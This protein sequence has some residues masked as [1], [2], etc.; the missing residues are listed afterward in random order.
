[1]KKRPY[2]QIKFTRSGKKM[3]LLGHLVGEMSV[4]TCGGGYILPVPCGAGKSTGIVSLVGLYP[5]EGFVIFVKTKAECRDMYDR[6]RIAGVA[7]DEI[8]MIYSPTK[9]EELFVERCDNPFDTANV[10]IIAAVKRAK[11]AYATMME[12]PAEL[13][14]KR[15]LIITSQHLYTN[16]L[17]ALFAYTPKKTPLDLHQ[18]IGKTKELLKS[19]DARKFIIIDEQ[20]DFIQNFISVNGRTTASHFGVLSSKSGDVAMGKYFLHPELLDMMKC[21]Y[22]NHL[23][24]PRDCFFFWRYCELNRLKSFEFLYNL[25]SNFSA[26]AQKRSYTMTTKLNDLISTRGMT[27]NLYLFDATA[28]ILSSYKSSNFRLIAG[29]K[30]RYCS[31]IK[32]SPFNLDLK[33]WYS[34]S[35]MNS[36][37]LSEKLDHITDTLENQIHS[38]GGEKLLIVTWKYMSIKGKDETIGIMKLLEERLDAKGLNGLYAIIYRG[39]GEDKATNAY[40]DYAG[41]TFLG[42]WLVKGSLAPLNKNFNIKS[43]EHKLRLS[44][45]AQTVCRV[46]I[47][48]HDG[49]PIKIFYSEDIDRKIMID[50]QQY[51]RSHS[52]KGVV[53]E[54]VPVEMSSSRDGRFISE[55][56][57]LVKYD[58]A[59]LRGIIDRKGYTLSIPLVELVKILPKGGKVKSSYRHFKAR[60]QT[61]YKIKL[62]I[63]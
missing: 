28:D 41:V 54:G 23:C 11:T 39:S 37:K 25:H 32:F 43:S 57:Q 56:R 36:A 38:L 44:G 40:K 5:A 16:F 4:T 3:T 31:P 58:P 42:E 20:P 45:M 26:I 61:E 29:D 48:K 63:L 7:D 14:T 51:F 17:P 50:L 18:Y 24:S 46:R 49:E 19:P 12:R 53:V 9:E 21:R 47:R 10:K 33:R 60:L 8:M 30:A 27:S 22:D 13:T 6:L 62:K 34:E 55:M 15:V 2:N 1:M 52:D 35:K 59:L